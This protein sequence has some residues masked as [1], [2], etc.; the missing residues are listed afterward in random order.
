M[1]GALSLSLSFYLCQELSAIILLLQ[2]QLPL[3]TLHALSGLL[4]FR[5]LLSGLDT[6][7]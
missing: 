7:G 4:P 3:S 2:L 6:A 5:A 1:L